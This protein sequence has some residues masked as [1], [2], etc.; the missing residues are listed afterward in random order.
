MSKKFFITGAAG[1]IG[2]HL[3]KRLIKNGHYVVGFDNLNSYYD[4]NLKK[5]R[6]IE[7][8]NLSGENN[9]Y[10]KFIK[11]E[12]EDKDKINELLDNFE[13]NNIINLAAQAGVRYSIENPSK[14]INSNIVGFGNL[15]E[16]CKKRKLDHFIYASSSSIY[17]GNTKLPFSEKDPVDNPVSIYAATKKSNELM[18]YAYSHLY[19]LP[20]SGARFFTVY[21]PWG[22]PDMAPMI[23]SKAIIASKPIKVFNDGNMYRDFTYIDDV[24]ES[25]I[26]LIDKPPKK[27]T[28]N[29][30][31]KIPKI[32]PPCRVIN[33]GNGKP[34]KLMEFINI[35]EKEI[36]MKANK[37]FD[38][39][40]P[41]DIKVTHADTSFIE[42]LTGYRPKT[43][44]KDGIKKFIKW[45]KDYYFK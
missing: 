8:N 6:L 43:D 38:K 11:G 5:A 32:I 42:G 3:C 7:L 17:G 2:F 13:P 9:P 30:S 41:G 29:N 14:Y 20:I 23:F 22:R 34:I 31:I 36:G 16:S 25:L 33:I 39:L 27:S 24:I 26:R 44:L 12:L 4:I 21:G 37:T 18:A 10:W 28:D 19:D 35:L 1:F 45:Y 40:Q 15:L